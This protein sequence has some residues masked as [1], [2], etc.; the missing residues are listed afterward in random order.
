MKY[1]LELDTN[2]P[3]D[4][5]IY[6]LN[7]EWSQTDLDLIE[8]ITQEMGFEQDEEHSYV[9]CTDDEPMVRSYL[10]MKGVA[11][12]QTEDFDYSSLL[13]ELEEKEEDTNNDCSKCT[14]CDCEDES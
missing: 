8:E 7:D 5:Y 6:F 11:E 1:R 10:N 2:Y 4:T 14:E 9:M 13:D 12:E 3:D